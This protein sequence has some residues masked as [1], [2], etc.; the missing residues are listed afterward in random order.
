M[1]YLTSQ[2]LQYGVTHAQESADSLPHV[3][4]R[5]PR[6][7]GSARLRIQRFARLSGGIDTGFTRHK[8]VSRAA[9]KRRHVSF[10]GPV[11]GALRERV[12]AVRNIK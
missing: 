6:N 9:L 3:P 4:W 7:F 10:S 1:S 5:K 2:T 11:N 12:Q 8:I